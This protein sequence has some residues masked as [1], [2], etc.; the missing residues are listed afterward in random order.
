MNTT[1]VCQYS[2]VVPTQS[3]LAKFTSGYA[4]IRLEMGRYERLHVK[5]RIYLVCKNGIEDEL[6]VLL[7]CP[8][9]SDVRC[10]L[11]KKRPDMCTS[12]NTNHE[13]DKVCFLFSNKSIVK[14]TVT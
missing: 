7:N 11:L 12:F 1:G 14:H 3:T 9:Y 6:H 8:L 13:V 4:P 2:D 10:P 5:D